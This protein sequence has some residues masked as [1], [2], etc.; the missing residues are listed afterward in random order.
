MVLKKQHLKKIVSGVQSFSSLFELYKQKS[1]TERLIHL[2]LF[3]ENRRVAKEILKKHG[4]EALDYFKLQEGK[5]SFIYKNTL[6]VYR[7]CAGDV[8]ALGDPVGP[9][10]EIEEAIKSFDNFCSE[11]GW[12]LSFFQCSNAYLEKYTSAKYEK[13][14]IGSEAIVDL[15]NFDLVGPKKK[16]F[17][18]RVR[19]LEKLGYFVKTYKGDISDKVF[20]RLQVISDE[21]LDEPNRIERSFSLGYFNRAYIEKSEILTVENEAGEIVAF[22]N[23]IP[24]YREGEV[25]IDLMRKAKAAPSGVMDYIF[26]K[27]ILELQERGYKSLS[28][29]LAP[30]SGFTKDEKSSVAEQAVHSIFQRLNFL[31]NYEG[32]KVFKDKF[33][34]NWHPKFLAFKSIPQLP[35]LAFSIKRTLEEIC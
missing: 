27:A 10:D 26:V 3:S 6:I 34:T 29:G 31:F 14:K 24:S 12:K 4:K 22:I 33:A 25:A 20:D 8:I 1:Q 18:N 13:I 2:A 7:I 15:E 28:L 5:A 9:E 23:I 30:M 17:R 16:D 21:W 19:K 11:H 35:Q 32:L